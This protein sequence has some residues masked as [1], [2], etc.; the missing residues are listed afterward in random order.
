M[1]RYTDLT[2]GSKL[3]IIEQARSVLNGTQKTSKE[4][5]ELYELLEKM[6]QFAY[7]TEVLLTKMR[8]DEKDG[9]RKTAAE[10]RAE[11]EKL[12][13]YIYQD[14]SLPSHFKFERAIRELSN[15]T[16]LLSTRRCETLGLAGAI[17]K[18][19]WQFDHQYKNLILSRYYYQKGFA[20]WRECL[21]QSSAEK[22]A[23]QDD[24]GY[25]AINFAY[26]NELMA[27]DK[28]EEH[29]R[30]T[31]ISNSIIECFRE[32]D[33]ARHF[34]LAEFIADPASSEPVLK[35]EQVADWIIATV[36][37]AFFGLRRYHEALIF[38]RLYLQ[39]GQPMVWE[40]RSFQKQLAS[41]AYLQVFQKTFAEEYR[42]LAFKDADKVA[43]IA[44]TINTDSINECLTVFDRRK[45][46]DSARNEMRQE[47]KLGI[48]LSGG[49]FRASLFHIGVFAALAEKDEL[50]N[51]EV[52]SCVSGGSIIGA[53]YYLKLKMLL[54]I[55]ADDE[56]EQEDYI[57]LVQEMERDFL[58]GVQD[59]L[60]MRIFNDLASNFRMFRKDY[61][62]THRLGELY[63]KHLYSRILKDV[64]E[65]NKKHGT[66]YN[67]IRDTEEN[68]FY[69]HDLFITPKNEASNF[70]PITGNWKRTNKIPQLVLNATSV[71]TG[72]NWQFTASWMGEPP[73]NIQVDI[74]AKPRLRRMYYK[75]AP[76]KYQNFR[77]GYAVGASSC[78]PVMFHPMPM[79]GLYPG[80][81]LQ[82]VDGGLHDNQGI[83]T[84]LEQECNTLFI[85]DASG[86]LPTN[87]VSTSDGP[88]IFMRSDNILQERLR[89]LQFLDIKQ[90]NQTSQIARLYK[91]HLKNNLQEKPVNWINCN[92][93]A[94]TLL[95]EYFYD[96]TGA[97][98][99]FG[100]DR[101][102][103]RLLSEIRTD[104]DSFNDKEAYA[105]MYNGYVQ[106]NF[107]FSRQHG[108]TGSH[109]GNLWRFSAIDPYVTNPT[110]FNEIEHVLATGKSQF[111]KVYKA[112]PALRYAVI[113]IG[114]VL[115]AVLLWVI[116][117][118]WEKT[119]SY[120]VGV[121][122][123]V[124]MAATFVIGFFSRILASV[125]NW[126]GTI[127]KYVGLALLAIFGYL[128]CKIY[129]AFF[130]GMYN[131]SGK[132][133]EQNQDKEP[134][135]PR[136]VKVI[137]KQET[138]QP[139]ESDK[140]V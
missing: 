50:K 49:G 20:S 42:T 133:P 65:Y 129:L 69:M 92:D 126:K 125:L 40:I 13:R 9:V 123:L 79:P 135:E 89:E 8:L 74:D 139:V 108:Q 99:S 66:N 78:V 107:E 121:K 101:R 77:L 75:E 6:D 25:T 30:V 29:G 82:L 73:G 72:H 118:A 34:I 23:D 32:A 45:V 24:Q 18:R 104:L 76:P 106:A 103:Q 11:Y 117:G 15:H 130:N 59:N 136:V 31:G 39:Q 12:A 88:A 90:R 51:L 87:S 112:S 105:L 28:M 102:A 19:K 57:R 36:A 38:I 109:T 86:Q 41:L 134:G 91:V 14:H 96:N 100:V 80:V 93:P 52:I 33:D 2:P 63:E 131:R 1:N 70:T 55:K 95:E 113:T 140:V 119:I 120:Q 10:L 138:E 84:L 3:A 48:A 71:N 5:K 115:A 43:A 97:R 83:A 60:R 7:A 132:M 67:L 44:E 54:E 16:D 17:Y 122:A 53:Y 58:A 114:I 81:D 26:I 62:R 127:K 137:E 47:R 21:R 85:S 116:I 46:Q 22:N 98:T 35:N 64:E 124:F 27:V 56:I 128:A 61:S 111:L 37:E 4:L 68:K 110:K 94:R